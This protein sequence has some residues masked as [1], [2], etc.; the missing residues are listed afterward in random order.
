MAER[1]DYPTFLSHRYY[2]RWYTVEVTDYHKWISFDD[3]DYLQS[4]VDTW[5]QYATFKGRHYACDNFR[6]VSFEN[7][8]DAIQFKLVFGGVT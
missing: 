2:L 3:L 7:R 6:F 8:H 5:L 1:I 4:K